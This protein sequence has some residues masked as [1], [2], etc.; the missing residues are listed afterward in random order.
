MFKDAVS[1]GS[2]SPLS[3]DL[4]WHAAVVTK[5]FQDRPPSLVL[6]VPGQSF[7]LEVVLIREQALLDHLHRMCGGVLWPLQEV[8]PT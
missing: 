3:E 6:L 1:I 8:A 2:P 7:P 5:L 4:A